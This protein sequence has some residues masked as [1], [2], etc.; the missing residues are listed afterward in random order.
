MALPTTS[1]LFCSTCE[2][3]E[4]QQ[5]N[6]LRTNLSERPRVSDAKFLER[7]TGGRIKMLL[8]C[9]WLD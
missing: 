6:S 4:A 1:S 2:T 3:S 8:A 9:W 7:L 5:Y